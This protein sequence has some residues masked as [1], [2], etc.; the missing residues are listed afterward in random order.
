M[1][2]SD[3]DFTGMLTSTG[4]V[5]TVPPGGAI[6]VTIMLHAAALRD[7]FWRIYTPIWA[8]RKL[9]SCWYRVDHFVSVEKKCNGTRLSTC[10]MREGHCY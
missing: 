4:F 7:I 8:D 9:E 1:K 6:N 2:K 10:V 5:L 3:T